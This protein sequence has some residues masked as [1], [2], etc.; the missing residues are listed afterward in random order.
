MEGALPGIGLILEAPAA[1][2]NPGESPASRG[3]FAA[4]LGGRGGEPLPAQVAGKGL[5]PT[6]PVL[7]PSAPLFRAVGQV[8]QSELSGAVSAGPQDP[9]AELAIPALTAAPDVVADVTGAPVP[10]LGSVPPPDA[11]PARMPGEAPGIVT[12]ADPEDALQPP[13]GG[14]VAAAVE[15]LRQPVSERPAG[16]GLE[17]R[18]AEAPSSRSPAPPISPAVSASQPEQTGLPERPVMNASVDATASASTVASP[19][20]TVPD[21]D[22]VLQTARGAAPAPQAVLDAAGQQAGESSELPFESIRVTIR[23]AGG[24]RPL[25]NRE[26]VAQIPG[27]RQPLGDPQWAR[28]LGERLAVV[29]RGEHQTARMSLNPAHLG[30]IEIQLRMQDDQAQLWLTAQHPQ[31]REALESAMPRL[32]EMFAQ[33][34][35]DLS[36]QGASGQPRDQRAGASAPGPEVAT[37]SDSGS[38]VPESGSRPGSAR[39]AHRLLDDYA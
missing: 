9:R 31:A 11:D 6:G 36:Q 3:H 33:Q 22:A 1:Q 4:L 7:P 25:P 2:A 18:T 19:Y 37:A 32:R 39:G 8:G 12:L 20:R 38:A 27:P 28:S 13:N 16:S 10:T 29:V 5:P 21:S 35:I 24:E 15:A 14:P 30:P 23:E 34:G 17:A 26:P